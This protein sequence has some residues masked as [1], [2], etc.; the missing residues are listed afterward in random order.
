MSAEDNIKASRFLLI[1]LLSQ[2]GPL[3]AG[4]WPTE[5][6]CNLW[7]IW[8]IGGTG[9]PQTVSGLWRWAGGGVL[10][11][12]SLEIAVGKATRHH[13]HFYLLI[14]VSSACAFPSSKT[15]IDFFFRI[16]SLS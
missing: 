12:A 9:I 14:R 10:P 13:L 5:K 1:A 16:K 15:P 3:P 11:L 6:F 8:E 2:A 7:G 4:P